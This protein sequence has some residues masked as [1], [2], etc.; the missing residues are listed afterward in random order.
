VGLDTLAHV[1]RT[2]QDQL[3]DDPFHACFKAPPVVTA[4]VEK[5]ALGQKTGAGF[6]RKEGKA[7]L[8]LDPAAGAYVPAD[9]CIDESVAAILAERDP[10]A[11]LKALHASDHPQARFVWAVLRD[12]FHYSA[13]H[14][15]EIADT[16]RQVDQAMAWGFGHARGP[17]ELWQSAGW[18]EIAGWIAN[19]IRDGK[20]L[21]GA[22]LPDWVT[23][24]PVWDAGGV[25]TAEGSWNPHTEKFEPRSTLPV[26]ER[27]IGAPRL[28]GESTSLGETT[29]FENEAVKCWTLPNPHPREVLILSFKTRMHTLSPGVVRGIMQAV[30]LA[31]QSFKALVIGQLGEPFSAGADL[32]AMLP[33]F[34]AGGAAAVEPVQREM[35][36]MVLRL[37][38]AQI[39]V[40]AALAGMALGGGCELALHC[41]S[42]VAHFETAIGLVEAGIGLV[43]GAGGLTYCARRAAEQQALTAP[44]A[45]LLAFVKKFAQA[46]ATAQVSASALDARHIGYLRPSDTIVMNRH[47]L[48]YVATRQALAMAE[49]GWR[50][51]VPATFPVAGRDGIATLK[52]QLLNM[53]VGGYISDHDFVVAEKVAHV[54]CGGDLDPG[55]RVDEAW[56]LAREREAFSSLLTEPK[57]QERITGFLKTGKPVRN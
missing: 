19:D 16:A 33:L 20:T 41:A 45:P 18:R 44:D 49:A 5:G 51:P 15:A 6:Y 14:L 13:V 24:G 39:P 48:L 29:V 47:E 40:I 2:M 52:A 10:A 42:R 25:Q 17:F 46:V 31:E 21:A 57:T 3:P 34:A 4:L 54:I 55:S 35:Q 26:Y 8:R 50:P 1:V 28:V 7:I 11:R 32:K 43:P 36:D 12:S 22:P 56:M 38:Y 27:Q 30:D 23:R 9:A 53:K 37:R